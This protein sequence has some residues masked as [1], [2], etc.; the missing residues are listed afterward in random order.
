M[1]QHKLLP[2]EPTQPREKREKACE[3]KFQNMAYIYIYEE[4]KITLTTRIQIQKY[5]QITW[6]ERN[7]SS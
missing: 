6:L 2:V 5:N 4:R 7:K 1:R 3:H